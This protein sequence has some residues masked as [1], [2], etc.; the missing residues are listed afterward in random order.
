[1]HKFVFVQT[2]IFSLSTLLGNRQ[3]KQSLNKKKPSTTRGEYH[4]LNDYVL[5]TYIN[6]HLNSKQSDECIDFTVMSFFCEYTRYIV[7]KMFRSL[8]L[9]VVSQ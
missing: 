5:F 9:R 4:R 2:K 3:I 8:I 1:M 6:L 7:E